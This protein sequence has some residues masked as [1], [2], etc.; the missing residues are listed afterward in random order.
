MEK[1]LRLRSAFLL[2]EVLKK[3]ML[4]QFGAPLGTA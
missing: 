3:F 4:E 2:Y 1:A